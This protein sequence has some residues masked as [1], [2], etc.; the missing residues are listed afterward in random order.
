MKE[1][2]LCPQLPTLGMLFEATPTPVVAT[3]SI[4]WLKSPSQAFLATTTRSTSDND[5]SQ[6]QL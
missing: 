2:P 3:T 4:T 6:E 5:Q 1:S